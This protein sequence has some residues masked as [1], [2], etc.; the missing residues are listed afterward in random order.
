MGSL[1]FSLTVAPQGM[2][3]DQQQWLKQEKHPF[4][5]VSILV[6]GVSPEPSLTAINELVPGDSGGNTAFSEVKTLGGGAMA[7]SGEIVE[8]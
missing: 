3:D 8:R 2:G 6:F 7:A 4:G 1:C 5:S